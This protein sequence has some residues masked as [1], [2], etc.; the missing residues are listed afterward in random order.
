M[1]IM[2]QDQILVVFMSARWRKENHS[3]TVIVI[4]SP[5]I[6]QP[7]NSNLFQLSLFVHRVIF[8]LILNQTGN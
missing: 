8:P 7:T 5:K 2:R 6:E 3:L 1:Q 4:V